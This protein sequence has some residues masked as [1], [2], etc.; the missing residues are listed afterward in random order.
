M[1]STGEQ[2]LVVLHGLELYKTLLQED[3]RML[4]GEE[5]GEQ[6]PTD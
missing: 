4:V 5:A 3:A 6:N 2:E 1:S